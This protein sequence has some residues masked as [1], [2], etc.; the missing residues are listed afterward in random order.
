MVMDLLYKDNKG[1]E[2]SEQR[3]LIHAEWEHMNTRLSQSGW[4]I[5]NEKHA[6]AFCSETA[7]EDPN[8]HDGHSFNIKRNMKEVVAESFDR[9][10]LATLVG[11]EKII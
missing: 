1:Q 8:A 4:L 7:E 6:K 10:L 11:C 5:P 2:V 3:V 9:K